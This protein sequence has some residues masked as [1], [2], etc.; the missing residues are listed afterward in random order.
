MARIAQLESD[1][2]VAWQLVESDFATL[3]A[4]GFRSVVNNRPDGET[5]GQ[6]PSA[7]A[8][9]A[10]RRHGL[11]FRYQ[12]V[13]GLT[14]TDDDVVDAFA[15]TLAE[16]PRPILFYCRSG[17]RCS[18][19]WSQAMV[20]GLGVETVLQSAAR[21]GYDLEDLREDLIDRAKRVEDQRGYSSGDRG[22]VVGAAV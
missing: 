15:R 13:D 2:F 21:A 17:T 4:Q 12:P 10:A 14:V 16:L 3:A 19:V 11:Q 1:V 22:D 7:Q 20:G 6:L 9:A 5:P 18:M 8:Q